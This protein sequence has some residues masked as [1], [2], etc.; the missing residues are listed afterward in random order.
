MAI[1]G[2]FT[3][4]KDGGWV[5]R[6]RTLTIDSKVRF[7]PNDRRD[8]DTAPDYRVY[9]GVSEAG[10]AWRGRTGEGATTYLRVHLDDPGL[11]APLTAAMIQQTNGLS[12]RLVWG[13]RR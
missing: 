13:R 1:I 5:G 10:A 11:P 3:P 6:I 7:V 8:T 9:V 2:V 12:A 4:A